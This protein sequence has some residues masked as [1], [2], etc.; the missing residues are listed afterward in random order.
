MIVV[1]MYRTSACR[2]YRRIVFNDPINQH[3]LIYIPTKERTSIANGQEED[4][5]KVQS[6]P[7]RPPLVDRHHNVNLVNHQ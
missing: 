4:V 1:S 3:W 2:S 6:I 7:I 5:A